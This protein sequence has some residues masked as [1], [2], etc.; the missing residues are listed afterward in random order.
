MHCKISTLNSCRGYNPLVRRVGKGG[1]FETLKAGLLN[2][3]V[4]S[5]A[6]SC[7]LV[8]DGK[9]SPVYAK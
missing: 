1:R 8:N 2:S 6:T 3:Q 4:H 9:Y 7:R 5:D